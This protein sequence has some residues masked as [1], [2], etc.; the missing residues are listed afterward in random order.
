MGIF[1]PMNVLWLVSWFPNRTNHSEGDFIERHAKAVAPYVNQLSII[2][3]TKDVSMKP[4]AVDIQH[5]LENNLMIYQVY[6]GP[7]RYGNFF[8]KIFSFRKYMALQQQVFERLLKERAVPDL[9]HV[10]VC[11]KAGLFALKLKAKYRIPFLVT[12]HWSGY[13]RGSIASI[14]ESSKIYRAF[15]KK[16]LKGAAKIL[17]VSKVLGDS[18][19][20]HFLKIN[21]TV[22][23]N[24]VDTQIFYPVPRQGAETL[25]LIHAS[26]LGE[27][28]NV[29]AIIRALA[30]W[31]EKGGV[32]QMEIF[33]SPR[34]PIAQLAMTLGLSTEVKFFPEVPQAELAQSMRAADALVLYS[35]YETFGCV[36]IEANACG[37]PVIVSDLPV[38]HE[39]LEENFNGLFV[40]G[41]DPNELAEKFA[42]FERIKNGLRLYCI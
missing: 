27:E 17:T 12:E 42:L 29:T 2:S 1:D 15:S 4:G 38:F 11:M 23:P 39:L 8:E 26:G 37:I 41:D 6:Y 34:P 16:I 30:I 13:L 21:F 36:V 28:K 9:V 22:L 20:Q 40:K 35:R 10:Q 32:F 24:V 5:R 19:H 18:I 31:K 14:Y 33:G 25:R 7:G 3:V